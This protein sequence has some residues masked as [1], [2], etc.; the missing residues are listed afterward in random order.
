MKTSSHILQII[1]ALFLCLGFISPS[2]A[3]ESEKLYQKGLVKEEG[4]GSLQEAIEIYNQVVDDESADRSIRAQALLHVGICYEKLGQEKAKASYEKLISEYADQ[5]EVVAL[6]KKK[7][8]YLSQDKE[9]SNS[10]ELS[11]TQVWA[12]SKD[13]YGV[14]PDGRYL[15][16]IDW[17]AAEL[18][19]KDLK[20]GETRNLTDKGTWKYPISFPDNS[21]W[22]PDSKQLAYYWYINDSTELRIVNIDGSGDRLL[23]KGMGFQTPWPI[24]WS[25]DGKFILALGKLPNDP[26]TDGETGHIV[27]VSVADGSIRLIKELEPWQTECCGDISSD[28]KYIIYP[29]P[30]EEGKKVNDLYLL[31]TDG[32]SEELIV[33]N[34][35]HDTDPVWRPDGK[36]I[37]FR[38]DRMGTQDLW[39]LDIKNGKADGKPRILKSNLGDQTFLLGFT[40]DESLFYSVKNFRSDIFIA[41]V[42]FDTGE[43][44]SE[45]DKISDIKGD[46]NAK[47]VWSPDG[48]YVMYSSWSPDHDMVLGKSQD[49][50]IYDTQSKKTRKL[51]MEFYA[52]GG[53]FWSQPRW[54]PDGESLLVHGRTRADN[55]QG[56]FLINVAKGERTSILV[57]ER[58]PMNISTP[59]GILPMFSK[60]G[61][62]IFY[63][64]GDRKSIVKRN[65]DT[66][67]EISILAG[68]DEIFQFKL[69]PDASRIIFGYY[70]RDRE[71]LYE[72]PAEGGSLSTVVK[73]EEK[74]VRPYLTTKWLSNDILLYQT[75]YYGYEDEQLIWRTQVGSGIQEQ[76]IRG[77]DLLPR[78]EFREL[79]IH[80]DGQQLLIEAEIGQGQEIWKMENLLS[81]DK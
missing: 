51:D 75:G 78:A 53:L 27:T 57:K 40:R 32:S 45:P 65:L 67:K 50:L 76:V 6:G 13:T 66:K 7:L 77:E 68:E 69:S 1:L 61:K 60:D 36:G 16:Y 41:R 55:L 81:N 22:S 49:M 9:V 64:T 44:L 4:E 10:G 42:N 79:D 8:A 47:P 21:I 11:I 28:S 30:Q 71:L 52:S 70:F 31:A 25:P 3:Q 18:A 59:V 46:R 14:S 39:A 80:P 38:S 63:L 37:V 48:R 34:V 23:K 33:N 2:L 43:I 5:E 15:N 73:V 54:S 72:V 19:V 56:F 62:D 58:E 35:A 17:T 12:P 29:L 24:A 20:T 74:G 26:A